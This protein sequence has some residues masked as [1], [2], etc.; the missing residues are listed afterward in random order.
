MARAAPPDRRSRRSERLASACMRPCTKSSRTPRGCWRPRHRSRSLK[1]KTTP[2]T[3]MT[4]PFRFKLTDEQKQ[5]VGTV[6]ELTQGEFK[7]RGLAYMNGA[8]P[9]ENIRRLADIGVLGMAVPQAY[10]GS[11]FA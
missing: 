7:G 4:D 3:P 10:G 6:R 2:E 9:W 11:E 1:N 5:I 8:F